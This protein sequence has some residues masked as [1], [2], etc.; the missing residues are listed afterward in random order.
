MPKSKD[1]RK[2][3]TGGGVPTQ[4]GIAALLNKPK[5]DVKNWIADEDL[6]GFHVEKLFETVI[7]PDI[8][9]AQ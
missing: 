4:A 7:Q 8:K 9:Q 2:K 6:F 3:K 5:D 1:P